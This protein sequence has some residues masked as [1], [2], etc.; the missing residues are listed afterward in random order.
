MTPRIRIFAATIAT[1]ATL[2][3]STIASAAPGTWSRDGSAEAA[4]LRARA[5]KPVAEGPAG[6]EDARGIVYQPDAETP[7]PE[8][9]TPAPEVTQPAEED[10][11][12]HFREEDFLRSYEL[13][14]IAKRGRSFFVPGVVLTTLGT[15]LVICSIAGIAE[16]ANGVTGGLLAGSLAM[17]AIGWPL[18]VVGVRMR[19]H[20]ERYLK[21]R[22]TATLAPGGLTLRF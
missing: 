12:I 6:A 1:A 8:T 22:R 15:I 2:G 13:E 4:T 17:S 10:V 9:P 16:E 3:T 11:V 7:M 5:S 18:L 21:N 20:P 19:K 14:R